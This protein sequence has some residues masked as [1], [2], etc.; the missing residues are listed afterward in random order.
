LAYC[1]DVQKEDAIGKLTPISSPTE[2]EL[3]GQSEGGTPLRREKKE[4]K[5]YSA[6]QEKEGKSRYAKEGMSEKV[7]NKTERDQP[8]TKM[9]IMKRERSVNGESQKGK[10]PIP[11]KKKKEVACSIFPGSQASCLGTN[12]WRMTQ[13]KPTKGGVLPLPH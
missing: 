8:T 13:S 12:Q 6:L 10:G 2:T 4:G 3:V 5:K 9:Q 1:R 11:V 7:E